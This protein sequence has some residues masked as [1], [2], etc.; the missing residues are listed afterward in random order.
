L[1]RIGSAVLIES[2]PSA[3]RDLAA[4]PDGRARAQRIYAAARAGYHPLAQ[5]AIDPLVQ[6]AK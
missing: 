4:T 5:S 6:P 1:S 3:Y 2:C